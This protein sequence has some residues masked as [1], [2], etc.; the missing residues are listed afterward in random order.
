MGGGGRGSK[1]GGKGRRWRGRREGGGEG[2]KEGEEGGREGEREG[3][4]GEEGREGGG[5][6]RGRGER[7]KEVVRRRP[8]MTIY[9][10]PTHWV[11]VCYT[12]SDLG[13][14]NDLSWVWIRSEGMEYNHSSCYC[15]PLV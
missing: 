4:G 12:V 8:L 3:R 11:N 1:E 9:S 7:G 15:L 6:D 14:G 5:R 10:I 2:G 13:I